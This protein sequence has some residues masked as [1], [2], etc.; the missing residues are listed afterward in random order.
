MTVE[1]PSHLPDHIIFNMFILA[2]NLIS[3][4]MTQVRPVAGARIPICKF[5]MN[6]TI[7]SRH[8]INP[9]ICFCR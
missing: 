2:K 7:N 6:D 4:G 9:Y 5:C 8:F 1:V 3:N